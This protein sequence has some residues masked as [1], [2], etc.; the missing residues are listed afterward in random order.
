MNACW[1]EGASLRSEG[2]MINVK[3]S[4]ILGRAERIGGEAEVGGK[5]SWTIAVHGKIKC[6]DEN[7]WNSPG[8]VFL[9]VAPNQ[10]AAE[11]ALWKNV[12]LVL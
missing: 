1:G 9:K 10:T 8:P 5:M 6:R 12:Y 7:T 11:G 2:E 3:N 4:L